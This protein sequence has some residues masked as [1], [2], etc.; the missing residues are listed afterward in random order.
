MKILAIKSS[1]RIK[2]NT[3]TIIDNIV[4]GAGASGKEIVEYNLDQLHYRGCTACRVC[5]EKEVYCVLKD[6][7]TDYWENL[8]EADVLIIGSPNYMGNICGTLKSFIDRHY[9]TK[10]KSMKSKL[11]PNKRVVL[12]FSQGKAD[13]DYYMNN[14]EGLKKYLETHDMKVEFIIHSGHDHVSEDTAFLKE[15]F[16]LGQNI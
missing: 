15:S 7:L 5:K 14:Y 4:A 10:D 13:K 16:L 9:C 1:P 2:G 11:K 6:D 8:V 12:V 3:N